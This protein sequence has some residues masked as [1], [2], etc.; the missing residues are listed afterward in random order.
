MDII[1]NKV[2]K[3]KIIKLI[4]LYGIDVEELILDFPLSVGI[5]NTIEYDKVLNEII[6]HQFEWELDYPYLFDD[7]PDEDK[8]RV[9][10]ILNELNT[11]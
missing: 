8:L 1:F 2:L 5:F 3:N 10:Q 11:I 7:L 4:K 6:L 9:Y